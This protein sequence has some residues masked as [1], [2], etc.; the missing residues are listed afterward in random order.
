MENV[1]DQIRTAEPKVPAGKI[2]VLGLTPLKNKLGSK[3]E[4]LSGLVHK[5]FEAAIT[6]AQSASDQYILLD[7][8]SYA[9]VFHSLSFP[10]ANSICS[11]IAREVC[12]ALFGDQLD[13][14]SVRSV[15]AEVVAPSPDATVRAGK[16]IED[17]LERIGTETVY[18]QSIQSGSPE[19][20]AIVSGK[21]LKPS[22]PAT[23]Q[24]KAAHAL[25]GQHGVRLGFFPVWEL[26]HSVSSSL[27][28]LPFSGT[29]ERPKAIGRLALD[30]MVDEQVAKV[31]IAL[32]NAAVAFAARV[33][34]CQ[35]VCAVGVS[36]SYK[37][38]SVFQSR[39][40]YVTALQ[41]ILI[42]SSTPLVLQIEQIPDGTPAARLGELAA[43]MKLSNIRVTLKFQSLRAIPDFDFRLSV[44]GLGGVIL[45]G[46]DRDLAVKIVRKLVH[47]AALQKAFAFVDDLESPDFVE[48]ARQGN[49]RFGTGTA[50]SSRHFSGLES[51]PEFPLILAEGSSKDTVLV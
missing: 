9:V 31:E 29:A 35:K 51:I 48:V 21:K 49:V 15:V 37:T 41:N 28:V 4:R 32:L 7:E 30:S 26:Q 10:E 23:D 40:R 2:H 45:K 18:A 46:A 47:T 6:R 44:S 42:Q 33:F 50:L 24:I 36:V 38:L 34:D 16:L 5:L 20:V 25:L 27:N 14:V 13:E 3:W 19:P 12:Q 17:M 43:M 1:G 11:A 39:I 8:L 22:L